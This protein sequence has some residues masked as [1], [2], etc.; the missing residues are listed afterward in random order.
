MLKMNLKFARVGN[1]QFRAYNEA[2]N[3]YEIVQWFNHPFRGNT[4]TCI[5]ILFVDCTSDKTPVYRCVDNR[6]FV[7]SD[8]DYRDLKTIIRLIEENYDEEV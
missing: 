8:E 1:I 2:E 6:P 5:T 4:E 3:K 7:L